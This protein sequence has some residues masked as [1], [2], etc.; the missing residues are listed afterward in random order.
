MDRMVEVGEWRDTINYHGPVA[1]EEPQESMPAAANVLHTSVHLMELINDQ[2]QNNTESFQ[3]QKQESKESKYLPLLESSRS[4]A[5]CYGSVSR[6]A[7]SNDA[8]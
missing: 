2:K 6:S 5:H 3:M 4:V 8:N 1:Q 7:G